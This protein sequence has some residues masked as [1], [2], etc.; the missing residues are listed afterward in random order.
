M[1]RRARSANS[2]IGLVGRST[3]TAPAT[4][5]RRAPRSARGWWRAVVS[6]RAVCPTDA[7]TSPRSASSRCSQ[8]SSTHQH[9][10]IARR[11]GQRVDR[12]TARLIGQAERARRPRPVR[13]RGR[14][15]APGRRSTTP[16]PILGRQ[17][18]RR[19]V[20]SEAGLASRRQAPVSVT[21]RSPASTSDA[22]RSICCGAAHEPGELNWKVGLDPAHASQGERS[23]TPNRAHLRVSA[24]GLS[25][26]RRHS[27]SIT[28][29][30]R[31]ETP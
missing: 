11:D 31:R 10:T 1:T 21:S 12:G 16:S 2:S 9:P 6:A 14:R 13:R 18:A 22:R 17:C 3:A 15:W 4:S 28:D 20:Q 27:R 19:S 24:D 8:L 29:A 7:A 30:N 25:S 23:P 5:P 26:I